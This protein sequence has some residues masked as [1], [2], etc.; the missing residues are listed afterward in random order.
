[1]LTKARSLWPDV[2]VLNYTDDSDCNVGGYCS[3]SVYEVNVPANWTRGIETLSRDIIAV[4]PERVVPWVDKTA[5]AII[6]AA[7]NLGVDTFLYFNPAGAPDPAALF[8]IPR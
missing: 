4:G 5:G 6:K 1:V 8:G 3:P 7:R 2:A